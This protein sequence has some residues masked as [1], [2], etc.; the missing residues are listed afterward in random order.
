MNTFRRAF[1]L[2]E[3]LV[4]I[5][6]IGVLVGLLLPA[7]Q[8]AREAA[9]RTSCQHSLRQIGIAILAYHDAHRTLPP[10]GIEWRPAGNTTKR[11]I[12]WSAFILPQLEEQAVHDLLD[13]GTPFDSAANA[14]GAAHVITAYLCPSTQRDGNLA[15]GRGACDFGG[16]YGER[17]TSPNSP[18]KG[19]MLYDVAFNLKKIIDGTSKTILIGE[20]GQFTDGQWINARNVFDQAYAINAAPP[21][22]ND[23]R[24]YHP[25]G[26]G[27]LCADG[28]T[29]YLLETMDLRVLAALCT[30]AR[31]DTVSEY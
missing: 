3:L 16:I 21:V 26:A 28:S 7:I 9:R 25:A 8:A 4:V 13:F 12:A 31:G 6:I 27:A 30:R 20:D 2:V 15:E 29:H 10:G 23:I 24:S 14:N 17:I 19:A 5:A 22:E 1:S 11:Q 18:P